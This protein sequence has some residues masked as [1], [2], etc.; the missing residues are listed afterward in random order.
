MN[1]EASSSLPPNGLVQA[2]TS[3][4]GVAAAAGIFQG[5]EG[6]LQHVWFSS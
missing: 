4:C 5:E 3:A 2:N 1:V 6:S